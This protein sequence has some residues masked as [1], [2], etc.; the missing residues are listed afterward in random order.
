[1]R[2]KLP[3]SAGPSEPPRILGLHFYARAAALALDPYPQIV[4]LWGPWGNLEK[5]AQRPGTHVA[6]GTMTL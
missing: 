2:A 4:Q 3:S 6:S 1:M 5:A